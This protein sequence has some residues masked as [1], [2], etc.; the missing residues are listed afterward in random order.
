[1]PRFLR[2]AFIGLTL[3]C[4]L[5]VP[6]FSADAPGEQVL[7]PLI[8]P[9]EYRRTI[10]NIFGDDID[11]TGRFEPEKREKGLL[12]VGAGSAHLS[13]D[14]L[15]RYDDLSRGIAAQVIAPKRRQTLFKCTPQNVKGRDDACARS[16]LSSTGRLLF[17][18][19]LTNDELNILV[20]IAGDT[21]DRKADF[22]AGI[23][24]ILSNMLLSPRFLYLTKRLEP[25]PSRPGQYR[26]DSYSR[27]T[28]LSSYLWGMAPDDYLLKAAEKGELLTAEGLRHQADRMVSSPSVEGGIRSFFRDMLGFD[29]FEILA[30]DSQ[31][32]P[33]YTAVINDQAQEQTLRTIVT[34]V[35]EQ[36]GDY[37]DLFTTPKTFLTRQLAA[38][39]RVPLADK[40]D[41][42][43][44]DRWVPF[45]YAEGDPRAGILSHISFVALHS[46]SGRSSP[47][48]RGKALREFL[49]CQPVPPPPANV[50]FTVV[51]ATD[52]PVHR[53]ARDRLSAHA[54][55]PVCAGC[56]KITDPIGL[57]LENFDAAGS[58]RTVENGGTIDTSGTLNGKNFK[59]PVDLARI[60]RED[61]AVTSCVASR[62]FAFAAGY[63]PPR[64]EEWTRILNT[65]RDSKYDVVELMRQIA[66][67]EITYSVPAS[68]QQA[69]V[70]AQ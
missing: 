18:R 4:A 22:Y 67:S 56:H 34:H 21:A 55:N 51:E 50:D 58:W 16:F 52:H 64:S 15:E 12:A 1:M 7:S 48:L 57:A 35:L 24:T 8:S 2:T 20:K 60:I 28:L 14:G 9:E 45:S 23:S 66:M 54:S 29:G 25:D 13:A 10:A 59:G 63:Q 11:I 47:T 40:T 42:D 6:A 68:T 53:T 27:A 46:P 36:R 32:F 41:N 49:L 37:R 31:F 69:S 30:K 5:S 33:E 61:P 19:P 39:Y 44:P 26:L 62:S 65:F 70:P 38:I 17:R 3:S 43:Q